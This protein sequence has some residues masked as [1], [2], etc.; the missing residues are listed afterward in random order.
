MFQL[1][2][3]TLT[4]QTRTQADLHLLARLTDDLET[5]AAKD[6][7]TDRLRT[8]L[9]SALTSDPAATLKLEDRL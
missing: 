9:A 2:V 3:L 6:S 8:P 1:A 5:R 4:R 7:L